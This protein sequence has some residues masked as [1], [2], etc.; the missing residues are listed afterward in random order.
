MKELLRLT[1]QIDKRSWPSV[2]T[3]GGPV[4][5]SYQL[6]LSNYAFTFAEIFATAAAIFATTAERLDT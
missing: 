5:F 1:G 6:I 4:L 2:L 3:D